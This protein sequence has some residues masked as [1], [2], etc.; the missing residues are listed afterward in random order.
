M[1]CLC[2][3]SQEVDLCDIKFHKTRA[4]RLK[5]QEVIFPDAALENLKPPGFYQYIMKPECHPYHTI[6]LIV[7]RSNSSRNKDDHL[8]STYQIGV[9]STLNETNERIRKRSMNS[10]VS[11]FLDSSIPRNQKNGE[12]KF[13]GLREYNS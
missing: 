4:K 6:Y 7:D 10:F 3:K 9:Q 5:E 12:F 1:G 13:N 2:P 8:C 11:D